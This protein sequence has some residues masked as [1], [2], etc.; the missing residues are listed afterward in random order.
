MRVFVKDPDYDN[1]LRSYDIR[2]SKNS[3]NQVLVSIKSDRENCEFLRNATDTQYLVDNSGMVYTMDTQYSKLFYNPTLTTNNIL[4][5]IRQK[6][7]ETDYSWAVWSLVNP[8]LATEETIK[9]SK[10]FSFHPL[11][12][13]NTFSNTDGEHFPFP[14]NH[15]GISLGYFPRVFCDEDEREF[16]NEFIKSSIMLWNGQQT[17]LMKTI[18]RQQ[19]VIIPERLFK[20]T[21]FLA[22]CPDECR[23]FAHT[24]TRS[25]ID[26]I[27][28]FIAQMVTFKHM[29]ISFRDEHL[30]AVQTAICESSEYYKQSSQPARPYPPMTMSEINRTDEFEEAW[31]TYTFS[32]L[33]QSQHFMKISSQLGLEYL[34]VGSI[35]DEGNIQIQQRALNI[36]FSNLVHKTS[37]IRSKETSFTQELRVYNVNDETNKPTNKKLF[38]VWSYCNLKADGTVSK[39][40]QEFTRQYDNADDKPNYTYEWESTSSKVAD[41]PVIPD[42]AT[43]KWK[44]EIKSQGEQIK[45]RQNMAAIATGS[46][47]QLG[48]ILN[49]QISEIFLNTEKLHQDIE[50]SEFKKLI[51]SLFLAYVDGMKV[52]KGMKESTRSKFKGIYQADTDDKKDKSCKKMAIGFRTYIALGLAARC[53]DENQ[54]MEEILKLT[55]GSPLSKEEND[56]ET[57]LTRTLEP[58]QED[59]MNRTFGFDDRDKNSFFNVKRSIE[60]EKTT[61][62]DFTDLKILYDRHKVDPEPDMIIHLLKQYLDSYKKSVTRTTPEAEAILDQIAH[63]TVEVFQGKFQAQ[64]AEKFKMLTMALRSLPDM[65]KKVAVPLNFLKAW[66]I[67]MPGG[68]HDVPEGQQLTS[69]HPYN[70]EAKPVRHKQIKPPRITIA[71]LPRGKHKRPSMPAR[72]RYKEISMHK[73]LTNVIEQFFEEEGIEAPQVMAR[74]IYRMWT[75][76]SDDQKLFMRLFPET[77]IQSIDSMEAYEKWI[78]QIVDKYDGQPKDKTYIMG[79]LV[80]KSRQKP[81]ERIETYCERMMEYLMS[82]K[83]VKSVEEGTENSIILT[84]S[85]VQKLNNPSIKHRLENDHVGLLQKGKLEDVKRFIN[86]YH[87]GRRYLKQQASLYN[88]DKQRFDSKYSQRRSH[89]RSAHNIE[90]DEC[91]ETGIGERSE[92]SPDTSELEDSDNDREDGIHQVF[93]HKK[94]KKFDKHKLNKH[95]GKFKNRTSKPYQHSKPFS[96][97]EQGFKRFEGRRSHRD[98]DKYKSNP[99]SNRGYKHNGKRVL[100]REFTRKKAHA[101]R[102]MGFRRV[103]ENKNVNRKDGSY[104]NT[105]PTWYKGPQRNFL[106]KEEYL[107]LR[108]KHLDSKPLRIAKREKNMHKIDTANNVNSERPNDKFSEINKHPAWIMEMNDIMAIDPQEDEDTFMDDHQVYEIELPEERES[109]SESESDDYDEYSSDDYNQRTANNIELH[110]SSKTPYNIP[111]D[112]EPYEGHDYID[113]NSIDINEVDGDYTKGIAMNTYYCDIFIDS[114]RSRKISNLTR[115]I[116]EDCMKRNRGKGEAT[117]YCS[118]AVLFDSGATVSLIPKAVL[119][120]INQ[121][122]NPQI[123]LLPIDKTNITSANKSKID[124]VGKIIINFSM[125]A[126]PLLKPSGSP[127]E[128]RFKD[129]VFYVVNGVDKTII[130]ENVIHELND[131]E[132]ILFSTKLGK[133]HIPPNHM[134]IGLKDS[135]NAKDLK[136]IKFYKERPKTK[137]TGYVNTLDVPVNYLSKPINNLARIFNVDGL[138]LKSNK[139]KPVAENINSFQLYSWDPIMI[140]PGK[141]EE[142]TI[143]H[144]NDKRIEDSY[145]LTAYEEGMDIHVISF[146]KAIV[147][148]NRATPMM[149]GIKD[150]IAIVFNPDHNHV[151]NEIHNISCLR[152]TTV[153]NDEDTNTNGLPFLGTIGPTEQVMDDELDINTIEIDCGKRHYVNGIFEINHL[154]IKPYMNCYYAEPE[155]DGWNQSTNEIRVNQKKSIEKRKGVSKSNNKINSEQPAHVNLQKYENSMEDPCKKYTGIDKY[156]Q[157]VQKWKD[158]MFVYDSKRKEMKWS[159]KGM[160]FNQRKDFESQQEVNEHPLKTIDNRIRDGP[161]TKYQSVYFPE[162]ELQKN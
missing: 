149:I 1:G 85:I 142:I 61:E 145:Q 69:L 77:S 55:G 46:K 75:Y 156:G 40:I 71:M 146:T 42:T 111:A 57:T 22:L 106:P 53:S 7:T 141:E 80:R 13:E 20:Q 157:W 16:R 143:G 59:E 108:E 23:N 92:S 153:F 65:E 6:L 122:Q 152:S 144:D 134:V 140:P 155:A 41:N 91:N 148:N 96:K 66:A 101:K 50:V 110:E 29:G 51:E 44:V 114:D 128:V 129:V 4:D 158:P 90:V 107:K 62:I 70:K 45:F 109:E 27:N 38:K 150:P 89:H 37:M 12:E 97:R 11:Y 94:H 139:V 60:T 161:Q 39:I 137:Y 9:Q 68:L 74:F 95:G 112:T 78:E 147:R 118:L 30:N 103:L 102:I 84:N 105:V 73:Y 25:T 63:M 32:L 21:E 83:G 117:K 104:R 125:I 19:R 162:G 56:D 123:E 58:I 98:K 138:E 120:R 115:S 34:K 33:Y 135:T 86:D 130:G 113:I 87:Q 133:T 24:I 8:I 43:S 76:R 10:G 54:T 28:L 126:T 35:D 31:K 136:V 49:K 116:Q 159:D 26:F 81:G 79:K 88:P 119:T 52:I 100:P 93:K 151:I 17:D 64:E 160:P 99:S 82:W 14:E 47:L 121:E 5:K 132:G 67:P 124:V 18:N 131:N 2:L 154:Q 36:Y 3:V 127:T 48:E 15:E 72:W